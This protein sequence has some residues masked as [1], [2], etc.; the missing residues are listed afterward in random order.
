MTGITN[1]HAVG[2]AR[3][4]SYT[5][6]KR[7]I[8]VLRSIVITAI[9]ARHR[10]IIRIEDHG[11]I[12]AMMAI[13]M[14]RHIGIHIRLIV[15]QINRLRACVIRRIVVIIIRRNPYSVRCT[16][17]DIPQ[18]RTLHK[19][20]TNDVVITVQIAVADHLDI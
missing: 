15:I 9:A 1:R 14:V 19:H 7:I 18:R 11:R 4:A 16:A 17:E 13:M 20:R 2:A 3:R 12:V 5:L 8:R 10:R 6:L